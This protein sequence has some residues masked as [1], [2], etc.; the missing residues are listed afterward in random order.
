[1]SGPFMGMKYL[2]HPDDFVDYT[3]LC[4]TYEKEILPALSP[5]LDGAFEVVID[6]GS[7]QG[8][9]VVGLAMRRPDL[10]I[11]GFESNP[12]GQAQITRMAEV[13]GVGGRIELRGYCDPAGLRNAIEDASRTF[14]IMDIDGG[15]QELMD[16]TKIPQLA[17]MTI[18]VEVHDPYVP[19]VT[20][21]I[22]ERFRDTHD[23]QHIP[24][25]PRTLVDL[26]FGDILYWR[27]ATSGPSLS[28][29]PGS[30]GCP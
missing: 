9:Y 21:L 29:R 22:R 16:P 4:G 6:V 18:L 15:E 23:I 5:L 7:A 19:G 13:N 11:I 28:D 30:P 26:P 24:T 25:N 3:M 2:N 20:E 27:A 17:S 1:M 12:E 8:Y 10:R 14:L